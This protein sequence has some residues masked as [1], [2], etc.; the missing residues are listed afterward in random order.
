MQVH[1]GVDRLGHVKKNNLKIYQSQEKK[2]K[3]ISIKMGKKGKLKN[4]SP[5]IWQ[6]N[7]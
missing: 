1:V 2:K 6:P 7:E 4:K 3:L 5:G